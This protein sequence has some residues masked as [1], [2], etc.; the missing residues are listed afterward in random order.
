MGIRTIADKANVSIATVSRVLNNPELVKE[1]T[2][3]KVLKIAQELN[4]QK[5]N[6]HFINSNSNDEI[7]VVLPDVSNSFFSRILE[8]ISK[9]AQEL[10]LPLNLYLTH[11]SK[12]K[13]SDVINKI[14]K[15][16]AKGVILIRA[17]N[18]EKSTI[19][20]IQKLNKYKI[21]FVLVDRDITSFDCPGVF[22]SNASAVYDSINILLKDGYRKIAIICGPKLSLNS[23]QRLEGYKEAFAKNNLEI[24][25]N[26]IFRG[27]FS[28]ESGMLNTKKILELDELPE[29]IFSCANQM[30]IGCIKAIA[31][32][33]LF[34][35]KDIKLF[36]FNKLDATNVN[37][38]NI[39]YVEHPVE[40]MG[41]RSV[42]ILKNKFVGTKGLI[43]EILNYK[44]NY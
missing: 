33:K 11:D 9:K 18:E 8:G 3:E 24:D 20:S 31:E 17:K 13:E 14:I 28:L 32:Q 42:N 37:N 36:S 2:R 10:D 41:E 43:R 27:D 25:E 38:F 44:I 4:Y 1:H 15:R 35:G 23:N 16:K 34:L 39:F 22:L 5:Y 21:P 7:G 30:T 29:V 26:M 19:K 6:Y 40:Y 12:D